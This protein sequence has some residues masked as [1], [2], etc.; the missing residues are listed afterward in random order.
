MEVKSKKKTKREGWLSGIESSIKEEVGGA[1]TAGT[2]RLW[3]NLATLTLGFLFG[4]CH[5]IFGSYPLGL[6]LVTALPFSVWLAALGVILG[7]LTLGKPGIIYAMICVLAVFLRVIIS[8]NEKREDKGSPAVLFKESL[9]L[10]ISSAVISGAVAG[11]YELLLEGISAESLLFGASMTVLPAVFVVAFAGA[12]YH[13]VGV[14]ELIFGTKRC[15]ECGEDKKEKAALI[16]FRISL[17]CF[18]ALTAVAFD[19]YIVFGINLSFVFSAFITLFASKRFGALYGAVVGFVSSAVVSGL[20]SPAFAL[21]GALSG[22]LFRFGAWYAIAAG[23]LISSLWGAYVSGVSGFLSILPEYLSAACI[24]LPILRFSPRETVGAE[25]ESVTRRATDMVGTMALAYRNRQALFAETV[26]Q[27]LM[28]VTPCISGFCRD[29][30]IADCYSA[31]LRML[32]EAKKKTLDKREL[33]EDMTEKI[34][35]VFAD[36]GFRD[37][38]IRAFGDRRKYIICSGRDTHGTMITSPNLMSD[39]EAVTG[40]KFSSPEYYRRDDMVLMECEAVAKYRIESAAAT[41][42]GSST[43]ISGDSVK[44]FTSKDLF[45]YGIIC[46]GMGSGNEAKSAADFSSDF[47]SRALD[48]GTSAATAF[49]MLN[50]ALMCGDEECSVAVD[51]FSLDLISCE[52]KFVKSGGACSYIKRG[53]SLFRIKSE[54]MPIGLMKRVDA[55]KIVAAVN[56][57]DYVIMLSDGVCDPSEDSTWLVELLNKQPPSDV[58]QY[59]DLILSSARKNSRSTDDMSVLVIR[60]E[61]AD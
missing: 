14:K 47:L 61:K 3:I 37:G 19:Q 60:I 49:H 42:G 22:F 48:L 28:S 25:K 44:S 27:T 45:A 55:E 2:F 34:E 58:R 40:L 10:R 32:T 41:A 52:G 23:G 20:Y 18:I 26:E 24:L 9:P 51:I 59:A 46:D 57:G 1:A 38:V 4:G 33:D 16:Y 35:P 15:F 43:E 13:G 8:G 12:F 17:L 39:I 56:P 53:D 54:T 30:N 29:T 21:A 36:F 5:L 11:I 31:C 50:S 7:S 6:A